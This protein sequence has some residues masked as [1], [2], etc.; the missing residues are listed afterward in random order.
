MLVGVGRDSLGQSQLQRRE[1]NSAPKLQ[2]GI[3]LLRL[4]HVVGR[5]VR[6]LEVRRRC[7]RAVEARGTSA[8]KRLAPLDR[9]SWCLDGR[10]KAMK[11]QD[12]QLFANRPW[13][14]LGEA[15]AAYWLERKRRLGPAEGIR[16]A[17]SSGLSSSP[18]DRTGPVPP[19]ARPT[20]S[21]TL[22][23][24]SACDV[25]RPPE[26]LDALRDLREVLDREGLRWYVFGA[27]AV[28]V[29][30]QPRLTADL[31][32]TLEASLERAS[33]LVPALEQGGFETRWATGRTRARCRRSSG[34]PRVSK[35]PCSR[36]GTSLDARSRLASR[37]TSRSAVSRG[38]P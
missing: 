26:L 12:L 3:D 37:V 36:A 6:V 2:L 7:Q 31:D 33:R 14:V 21:C 19:S 15:D 17:A 11:P 28:V 23:S 27:Q 9:R 5:V 34:G 13:E 18:S 35:P 22:E 38:W 30:G 10:L 16:M 4:I 29:Y 1:V 8:S 20:S 32:V 24:R 25:S